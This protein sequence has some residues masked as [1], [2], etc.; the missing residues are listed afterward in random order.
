MKVRF[1]RRDYKWLARILILG[2]VILG[3]SIV[4]ILADVRVPVLNPPDQLVSIPVVLGFANGT[5]SSPSA[6]IISV[7]VTIMAPDGAIVAEQNLRVSGIAYVNTSAIQVSEIAI[8][9]QHAYHEL[10]PSSIS[11]VELQLLPSKTSGQFT[12]NATM[13][14]ATEGD[15]G[16]SGGVRLSNGTVL[17]GVFSAAS[18][19]LPQTVVHV[20]PITFLID[21]QFSRVNI[22]VALALTFFAFVESQEIIGKIRDKGQDRDI[23]APIPKSNTPQ[24]GTTTSQDLNGSQTEGAITKNG[25]EPRKNTKAPNS[26]NDSP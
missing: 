17:S 13:F 6:P 9:F 5:P 20:E 16:V 10:T 26:D 24:T 2:E 4:L 15:W 25:S 19:N 7:I 14:W 1:E 22:A 8:D 12:G 18:P 23:S 3:L 21:E 11:E